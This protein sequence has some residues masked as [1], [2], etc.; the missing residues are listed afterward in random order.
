ML[1]HSLELELIDF[2]SHNKEFRLYE[3]LNSLFCIH[4]RFKLIKVNLLSA[5]HVYNIQRNYGNKRIIFI[6]LI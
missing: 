2:Y 3:E 1:I 4:W 6:Y 5:D